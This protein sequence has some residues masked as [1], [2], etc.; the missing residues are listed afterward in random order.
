[1]DDDVDFALF[2][3][4]GVNEAQ[5]VHSAHAEDE[6]LG[7]GV[8]S[9]SGSGEGEESIEE[10]FLAIILPPSFNSFGQA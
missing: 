3:G 5:Q 10:A 1:M 4:E 8:A 7:V 2:A 6:D 9:Q